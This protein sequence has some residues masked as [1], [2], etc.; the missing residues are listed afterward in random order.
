MNLRSLTALAS[1]GALIA[2]CSRNH[3]DDAAAITPAPA[4]LRG[5]YAGQFPCSNCTSV[6]ATLWLRDDQRFFFRQ[7]FA[8][9]GAVGTEMTYALGHWTWDEHA[10]E[11]V[12]RGPGP[13]RRLAVLDSDRL[14][15]RVAS[16]VEHVLARDTSDPAFKDR[17]K[18]DG[19]STAT[20]DGVVTNTMTLTGGISREAVRWPS[21]SSTV[22][23]ERANA[24]IALDATCSGTKRKSDEGGTSRRS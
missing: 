17:L 8:G 15:L 22:S 6:G 24:R 7:T 21:S 16:P 1:L 20:K 11:I 19:E 3:G 13:E 12:L 5:V 18:L 4:T 10:A 14:Q 9:D 2:G 23:A